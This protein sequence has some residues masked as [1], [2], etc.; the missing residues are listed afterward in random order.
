M[1]DDG[2]EAIFNQ[3]EMKF[4]NASL[5]MAKLLRVKYVPERASLDRTPEST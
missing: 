5:K 4:L 2:P 3:V 1:N